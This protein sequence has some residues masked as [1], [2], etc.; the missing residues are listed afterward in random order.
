MANLINMDEF[1][2]IR[3]SLRGS[4]SDTL[5]IIQLITVIDYMADM[6]EDQQQE[7][8]NLHKLLKSLEKSMEE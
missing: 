8:D 7:I 5:V 1:K 6:L 4:S 3:K 2:Q